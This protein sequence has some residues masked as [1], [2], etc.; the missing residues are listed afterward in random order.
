[1]IY[2]EGEANAGTHGETDD[3]TWGQVEGFLSSRSARGPVWDETG[4]AYHELE[5]ILTGLEPGE[6]FGDMADALT[7]AAGVACDEVESA[8]GRVEELCWR[9]T[10]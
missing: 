2:R 7:V 1:M 6:V 5:D 10:G 3:V 9:G 4:Q 8:E